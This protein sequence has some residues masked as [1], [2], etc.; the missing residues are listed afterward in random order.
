MADVSIYVAVISAGAGIIGATLSQV[1]AAVQDGRRAERDRRDRLA[2]ARHRACV[3]LLRTV[4]NLRVRV[5]N[6]QDYHGEDMAGR[7][8]EIRECAATAEAEAVSVALMVAPELAGMADQL[9]SAAA[10]L[11][12]A[13][14]ENASLQ[15]GAS[16]RAPDFSELDDRVAAFKA[17]AVADNAGLTGRRL[18]VRLFVR[19]KSQ[20]ELTMRR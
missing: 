17:L 4:L 11:A 9:A 16:T 12:T 1:T 6:I 8:A 15:L 7:L 2:D 13:A 3:R 19:R 18:F 20:R 14:I 10:R 5:A